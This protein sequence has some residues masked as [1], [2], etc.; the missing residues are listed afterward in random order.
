MKYRKKFRFI[1]VVLTVIML[2]GGIPAIPA[3]ANDP[4][5]DTPDL[6]HGI[7]PDPVIYRVNPSGGS[8]PSGSY[9]ID[10]ATDKI[11]LDGGQSSVYIS[12]NGTAKNQRWT[13]VNIGDFGLDISRQLNRGA[14]IRLAT[15]YDRKDPTVLAGATT[16]DFPT[17]ARRPNLPRFTLDF[18]E[19]RNNGDNGE[20]TLTGTD[21]TRLQ[22]SMANGR[23]PGTWGKFPVA[24][25]I[26]VQDLSN[27]RV[28]RTTYFLRTTPIHNPSAGD[29]VTPA[30]RPRRINVSGVARPTNFRVDYRNENIRARVGVEYQ[31]QKNGTWEDDTIRL[32]GRD[33][34]IG[35]DADTG[36]DLYNTTIRFRII[37]EAGRGAR[38][39]VSAW[40][41]IKILDTATMTSVD[42][43]N[44]V[45]VRNGRISLSSRVEV[46]DDVR[47]RWGTSVP[48]NADMM[49]VRLRA[50]ANLAR[51]NAIDLTIDRDPANTANILSVRPTLLSEENAVVFRRKAGESTIGTDTVNNGDNIN[52]KDIKKATAAASGDGTIIA[53]FD[54]ETTVNDLHIK[55]DDF[56]VIMDGTGAGMF[57]RT[58]DPAFT[59]N[60]TT[61]TA[62]PVADVFAATAV[63]R[64]GNNPFANT[65]PT[66]TQGALNIR[67]AEVLPATSADKPKYS[68]FSETVTRALVASPAIRPVTVYPRDD[69]SEIRVTAEKATGYHRTRLTFELGGGTQAWAFEDLE[70]VITDDGRAPDFTDVNGSIPTDISTSNSTRITLPTGNRIIRITTDNPPAGTGH[71]VFARVISA[72]IQEFNNAPAR[73]WVRLYTIRAGDYEPGEATVTGMVEGRVRGTLDPTPAVIRI[74]LTNDSFQSANT[75]PAGLRPITPGERVSSW[76]TNLPDGLNA[77]VAAVNY[78]DDHAGDEDNQL[79]VHITGT[80]T[81]ASTANISVTIPANRLVTGN[82]PITTKDNPNAKFNITATTARVTSVRVTGSTVQPNDLQNKIVTITLTGGTFDNNFFNTPANTLSDSNNWITNLPEGLQATA[83]MGPGT[84]NNV[85][86]ITI[87]PKTDA[88]TIKASNAQMVIRIPVAALTNHPTS[89]GTHFTAIENAANATF[90]ITP[91]SARISS[92]IVNGFRGDPITTPINLVITITGDEFDSDFIEYV[93]DEYTPTSPFMVRSWFDV[94]GVPLPTGLTASIHT[95]T[96]NIVR[97]SIAGTPNGTASGPIRITIPGDRLVGGE[98]ITVTLNPD[99]V[100]DIRVPNP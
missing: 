72:A 62:T 63:V 48:A 4:P 55:G 38:R 14:D 11:M 46:H 32:L 50:T 86:N 10:L 17:I 18:Y 52:D 58:G 25:G 61:P 96:T 49:K 76:F 77:H 99:A 78:L 97:I 44:D 7:A 3:F 23:N 90:N 41:T 54:V 95:V 84:S 79:T 82:A 100:Y 88:T 71:A 87:S 22:I 30:S 73:T 34:S 94:T 40:Q 36:T 47:D 64:I 20:W 31:V 85:V 42:A 16:W 65:I 83:A 91:P 39:P 56:R 68:V 1:A 28:Q 37:P 45:T 92:N 6:P 67:I 9:Y 53:V 43:L 69:S 60:I 24:R 59:I 74:T 29:S 26:Q 19:H 98:P 57:R 15:A 8:G 75:T 51:S 13:Q 66:F 5:S 35:T 70:F 27:N 93:N 89:G 12:F 21:V 2:A 81:A 80:P 33:L